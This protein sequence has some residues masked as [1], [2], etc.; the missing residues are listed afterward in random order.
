M[1]M[2]NEQNLDSI[3]DAAIDAGLK[4]HEAARPNPMMVSGMG[5]TYH[6]PDGACG[7]AWVNVHGIKGN[8]RIGKMLKARGFSKSYTGGLQ[9]WISTMTQ[10]VARKEAYAE[11]MAGVLRRH[12]IEAYADSR[13]D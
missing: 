8:T 4:A 2:V 13:L 12:G 1:K 11:A 10:S 3:L 9:Y 5:Q 6:V 7:F